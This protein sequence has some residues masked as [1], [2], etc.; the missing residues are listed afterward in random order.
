MGNTLKRMFDKVFGNREM[1]VSLGAG[2]S[3]RFR[4]ALWGW[5]CGAVYVMVYCGE[6][7]KVCFCGKR[8]F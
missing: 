7:D 6:G 8:R 3:E 5:F 4:A 2:S 1:R